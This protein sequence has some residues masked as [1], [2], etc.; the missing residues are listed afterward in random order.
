MMD[1]FLDIRDWNR[2][3][4]VVGKCGVKAAARHADHFAALV[5]QRPS[6]VA[7]IDRRVGLE[8]KL[9]FQAPAAIADDALGHR[10][11][12]P[13][14]ISHG[15]YGVTGIDVVSITQNDVAGFQVGGRGS[16]RR[17][18]ST[19]GLSAMISTSSMRRRLKPP[20]TFT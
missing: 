18:R 14:R 13:Q 11:L 19:N 6:R 2:K 10:A 3:A 1:E 5:E 17:A 8:E 20:G 7:G 9:A 4:Q 16:L 15:K 12:E